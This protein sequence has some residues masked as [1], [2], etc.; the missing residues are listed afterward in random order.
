MQKIYIETGPVA[1]SSAGIKN[2]QA[3]VEGKFSL[4]FLAALALAEGNVSLDKFTDHKVQDPIL[5]K[6]LARVEAR[7]VRERKFGAYVAVHMQN[8]LKI[9]KTREHPKGSPENPLSFPEIENKFQSTAQM[10]LTEKQTA[11]LVELVRNLSALTDISI[12]AQS[13][14]K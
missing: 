7:L 4:W 5:Q 10:H 1:F 3:G 9:E 8:G 11:G 14:N 13:L 2:P 12:L 6:L